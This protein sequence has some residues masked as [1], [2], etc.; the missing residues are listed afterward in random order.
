MS[1]GQDRNTSLVV[2]LSSHRVGMDSI[3]Y[4]HLPLYLSNPMLSKYQYQV[5]TPHRHTSTAFRFKYSNVEYWS[6][7]LQSRVKQSSAVESHWRGWNHLEL[8]PRE[9]LPK[10]L[11]PRLL[12][13][14]RSNACGRIH[15]S[16]WKWHS[17][18]VIVGTHVGEG[19][20]W[21]L[22]GLNAHC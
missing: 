12:H 4:L 21:L 9:A 15:H 2:P 7:W 6:C 10:Q 19:A 22:S 18:L 14:P 17:L 3:L 16:W 8:P 13:V 1:W 5:P 20:G 11:L